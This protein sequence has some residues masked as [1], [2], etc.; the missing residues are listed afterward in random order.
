M[1]QYRLGSKRRSGFTLVELLV[2]IAII[3][4]L[5]ALLLPAVQQAREAARRITCRNNMKQLALALHNYHDTFLVFPSGNMSRTGVTTDCTPDGDQCQDGR[6]SWTVLVL[7][8]IEQ[9]NLHDQFNFSLPM[10]WGFNDDYT[11]T[12]PDCGTN[13]ANFVPQTTPVTAFHCPSDPLASNTSLTNNYMGVMGGDTY[14]SNNNGSAYNCRM[15]GSR[16]NYNNGMLYLN[17]KTG[18]QSA[19]DGSSNV[20]L[21]GES[22]YLFQP[23][24]CCETAAWSSAARINNDDSLLVNIAAAT[25]QINSGDDPLANEV[26][27]W[28]EMSGTFG[29]HHPGGCHMAMG[30]GSIHFVSENINIDIHRQLSKRSDGLPTGGFSTP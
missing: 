26:H 13:N 12:N 3:G 23:N 22:K 11:G 18:F 17:S 15:N 5:I 27:M 21:V 14:P 30:D 1:F 9:Q 16:L 29:S 4:V 2:V 20:Y 8:F 24:F 6:A 25:F 10:Y 7:P 19:T 28:D